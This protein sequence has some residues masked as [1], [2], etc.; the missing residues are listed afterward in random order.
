[1]ANNDN[2]VQP[3]T[4]NVFVD[5]GYPDAMERSL[6]VRLAMEINRVIAAREL[7]QAGVAKLL[8]LHQP[9][10]SDLAN[11]RLTR[12][13]AERLLGFLTQL[14]KDVEIRISRATSK[15]PRPDVRVKL[16]APA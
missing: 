7:T 13:S 5:L 14:G 10:V 2:K 8:G 1:M 15:R 12:F 9:H 11:Y 16:V 4:G 6:R 3:G